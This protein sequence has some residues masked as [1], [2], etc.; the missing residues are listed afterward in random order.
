[1]L[2]MGMLIVRQA[3]AEKDDEWA[4]AEVELLH[5]L[6]ALINDFDS[7]QHRYFWDATRAAHLDWIKSHQHETARSRMKIYYE[8]IWDQMEPRIAALANQVA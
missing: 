2:Q 4:A 8:P 1:M 5:N 6:P 7:E 3:I